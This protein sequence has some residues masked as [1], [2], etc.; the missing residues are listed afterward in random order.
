MQKSDIY[1]IYEK[2]FLSLQ[3]EKNSEP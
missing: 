3:R 1:A 2:I